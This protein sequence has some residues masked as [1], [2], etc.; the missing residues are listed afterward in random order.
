MLGSSSIH[1]DGL[2]YSGG[3]PGKSDAQGNGAGG[4]GNLGGAGGSHG[5]VGVTGLTGAYTDELQNM[6]F[7][8]NGGSVTTLTLSSS[9]FVSDGGATYGYVDIKDSG[10]T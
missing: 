7:T 5:G 8:M 2:G 10:K 3:T 9:A 4:F 1:A 6:Y